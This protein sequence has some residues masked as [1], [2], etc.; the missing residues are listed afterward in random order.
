[1]DPKFVGPT[2]STLQTPLWWKNGGRPQSFLCRTCCYASAA[3]MLPAWHGLP[4]SVATLPSTPS[5]GCGSA[6]TAQIDAGT[7]L[8]RRHCRVDAGALL[9]R[10]RVGMR[11]RCSA[12]T[13][14]AR[15][16]GSGAGATAHPRR[17]SGTAVIR[18]AAQARS[19]LALVPAPFSPVAGVSSLA[20]LRRAR[21]GPTTPPSDGRLHC[22]CR[23]SMPYVCGEDEGKKGMAQ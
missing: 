21:S 5:S 7:L 12:A 3:R 15:N 13:A 19:L 11:A 1:M 16:R 6:G 10:H 14:W 9:H 2:K 18:A 8:R 4:P 17:R 20:S 22:P 23:S